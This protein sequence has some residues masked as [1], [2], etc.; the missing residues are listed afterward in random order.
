MVVAGAGLAAL[1]CGATQR[2][3]GGEGMLG[4]GAPAP[5]VSGVDQRGETR[6]TSDAAGGYLVVYFYPKDG[7]PG[8]TAE[9]CAFRDAWLR[10]EKAGVMVYGVSADDRDSHAEFAEEHDIPFPLIADPDGTW[11]RAFGVSTFLGM[12]SRVTFVIGPERT[13][14]ATY[15]DVDPGV[16]ATQLL[17]DI[18][19]LRRQSHR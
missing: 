14:V 8:C 7:T 11:T 6:S 12:T 1:S 10:Y 13:I 9:A 5:D 3:D 15:P 19:A 16:H 4:A 17:D 18:E 2:P